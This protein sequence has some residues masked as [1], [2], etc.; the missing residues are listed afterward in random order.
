[1]PPAGGTKGPGPQCG[2][3]ALQHLPL[4]EFLAQM[5][6][7]TPG[8]AAGSAA[9]MAVG[10]AAALTAKTAR[11]SIR[12][13]QDADGLARAADRWR[14]RASELAGADA[15]NVTAMLTPD[16]SRGPGS[17]HSTDPPGHGCPARPDPSTIPRQIGELAGEVARLAARLSELGNPRLR[18]D[19]LAARHLA[20][21]AGAAVEAI[22][23]S[24]SRR[25]G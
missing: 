25:L 3:T 1:M 12:H 13:L 4:S 14:E 6:A 2:P 18:A 19:A 11:L 15:S 7:T 10:M 22:V 8:P 21:A 20:E 9:A 5:S 17:P 16:P 24:N 23:R